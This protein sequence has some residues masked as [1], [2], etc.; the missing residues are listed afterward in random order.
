MEID[1]GL[2]SVAVHQ[3]AEGVKNP[4]TDAHT[5]GGAITPWT[6]APFSSY[7]SMSLAEFKIAWVAATVEVCHA[8]GGVQNYLDTR[9]YNLETR[10]AF[11]KAVLAYIPPS[12][13]IE[14]ADVMSICVAL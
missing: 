7:R 1:L 5:T 4:S 2:P 8:N 6:V 11:Y 10:E 9:Y 14:Y 12:D 13:A 3:S